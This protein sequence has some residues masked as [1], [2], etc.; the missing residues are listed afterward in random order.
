MMKEVRTFDEVF[1]SIKS[2]VKKHQAWKA[3]KQQR[4]EGS[5]EGFDDLQGLTD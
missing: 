3:A 5:G 2:K 4:K 1:A